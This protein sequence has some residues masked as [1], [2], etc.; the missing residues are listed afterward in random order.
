MT[1]PPT[2][3]VTP[4][5]PGGIGPI[6]LAT[7]WPLLVAVLVITLGAGLSGFSALGTTS[8]AATTI[9]ILMAVLAAGAGVLAVVR[10]PDAAPTFALTALSATVA[11]LLALSPIDTPASMASLTQFLLVG[12][13]HYL[14]IP[15]VVHFALA[16]GWPHRRRYWYGFMVGWYILHGAM[17]LATALGIVAGEDSLIAAVDGTFRLRL[18]EPA[19]MVIALAALGLALASPARRTAQRRAT[20]WAIVAIVLGAVPTIIA[21]WLPEIEFQLDGVLTTVHLSMPFL[22]LFGL[23]AVLS[24]PFAN[25]VRRDLL[26]HG[27]SQR[28]LEE[29]NLDVALRDVAT[30]LQDTFEAEG[31]AIRLVDPVAGATVGSLRSAPQ[32]PLPPDAETVDDRRTLVAPI[33]RGGDPFGEVRLE[34]AHAGAF[35]RREREWLT[36]FL[37]PVGAALRARRREQLLRQRIETLSRHLETGADRVGAALAQMP[38]APGEDGMGVPPAVDAREVLGQLSDGLAAVVRRGEEVESVATAARD[39]ARA[40]TD[41][42]ARAL[43]ELQRLIGDL[44]RLGGHADAIGGQNLGAQSVAFRTTL[45]ANNAALEATRAGSAGRTFGVLAEEIRRLADATAESSAAIEARTLTLAAD[46][47]AIGAATERVRDLLGGAI[48]DAEAGEEAARRLGDVAGTLLGD[49]R[50]LRPA[51]D[52][53]ATVAHRRSARDHHLT[54]TV[55]RF[56]DERGALARAMTQHRMAL[57]RLEEELRGAASGTPGA[58]R[59]GMLRTGGEER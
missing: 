44:L 52:E 33:G 1:I 14:L 34:A 12:P 47:A 17:W 16:I 5:A 54:A 53:A 20:A 30:A 22:A 40:A 11:S 6:P 2:D 7:A 35:G 25:P 57:G 13:W 37:G 24:L 48:Q 18:L 39:R 26:A 31:V 50:S 51:L 28:L 46:V 21:T 27:I 45:L 4:A 10:T 49:T 23:T 41:E 15:I 42:V 3:P 55:E 19:G 29:R 36:A 58:R 32:G 8:V 43:D 38:V 9:L 59:V 56:L